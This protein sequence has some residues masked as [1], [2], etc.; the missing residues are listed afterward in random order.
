MQKGIIYVVQQDTLQGLGVGVFFVVFL[1][2][3]VSGAPVTIKEALMN[4]PFC[5]HLVQF[6]L[7]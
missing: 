1:K 3:S 5:N 6:H 4:P 2:E 7:I